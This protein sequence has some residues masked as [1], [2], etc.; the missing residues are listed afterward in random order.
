[1]NM[2]RRTP[3]EAGGFTLLEVLFAMAIMGVGILA[4][5]LAQMSA[6][7]VSSGS[8][9]LSQAMY[10]AKE[11][12]DEL[13]STP[14]ASAIFQVDSV[15]NVDPQNP[16]SVTTD[17]TDNTTYTRDWDITTNAPGP[18]M[19]MLVVRVQWDTDHRSVRTQTLRALKS[20]SD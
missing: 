10:L 7:K 2:T 11:K 6:M 20:L 4:I 17:V 14:G 18:G 15:N 9:N 13:Q 8:K 16:I 5:A 3:H 12:M 19:V 1:M